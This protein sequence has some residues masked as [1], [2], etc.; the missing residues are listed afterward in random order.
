MTVFAYWMIEWAGIPLSFYGRRTVGEI[1]LSPA[2][3]SGE[4]VQ[5]PG[6]EGVC[7]PAVIRVHDLTFA[8]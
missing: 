5:F 1:D 8:S 6:R 7:L 3:D 4:I 2:L